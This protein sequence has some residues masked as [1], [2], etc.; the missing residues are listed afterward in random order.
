MLLAEG[1]EGKLGAAGGGSGVTWI[2]PWLRTVKEP[3]SPPD[4]VPD[5]DA[6]PPETLRPGSARSSPSRGARL[7]VDPPCPRLPEPQPER[8]R[9]AAAAAILSA[10]T[11]PTSEIQPASRSMKAG[12]NCYAPVPRDGH[13]RGVESTWTA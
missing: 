12:A 9:I 11:P 5:A 3:P 6:L 4:P 2:A 13:L 8:I 1:T 10:F 7:V